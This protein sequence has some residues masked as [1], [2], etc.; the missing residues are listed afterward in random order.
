MTDR[1]LLE[2]FECGTLEPFH[3]ADH[4]HVAFAYLNQYPPAE[5]LARFCRGLKHF[6]A[7]HGIENRYHETVTWAYLCLIRQ[8]MAEAGRQTW[9]AFR[10]ANPDLLL[11]KNGILSRYY[12]EDTLESE[13][14][15]AVFVF[16]DKYCG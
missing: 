11:W 3:H 6:A 14:A 13:R 2:Q 12:R 15:K 5:A 8:R 10:Q 9:E 16:P 7:L 4:V 1:Q